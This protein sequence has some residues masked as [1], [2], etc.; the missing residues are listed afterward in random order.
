VYLCFSFPFCYFFI[1]YYYYYLILIGY[2]NVTDSNQCEFKTYVASVL[3]P[4][5][6]FFF[7]LCY[8]FIF[9]CN[10]IYILFIFC[11]N[12]GRHFRNSTRMLRRTRNSLSFSHWWFRFLHLFMGFQFRPGSNSSS[13]CAGP[14]FLGFSCS[15]YYFF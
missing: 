15:F 10:F 3:Q 4:P 12:F 5:R 1:F 9:I 14:Y 2:L 7:S 11:S 8:K 13:T 6:T